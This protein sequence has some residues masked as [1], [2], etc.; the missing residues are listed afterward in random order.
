MG[1]LITAGVIGDFRP[2]DLLRSGMTP[3]YTRHVDI[4]DAVDQ[5]ARIS[6]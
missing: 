6:Q 5:I 1:E 2:S 3:L 4:W